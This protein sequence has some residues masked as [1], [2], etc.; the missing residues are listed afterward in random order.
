MRIFPTTNSFI[1]YAGKSLIRT[2]SIYTQRT[3]RGGMSLT[4]IISSVDWSA[5]IAAVA[6]L[7]TTIAGIFSGFQYKGKKDA[8]AQRDEAEEELQTTQAFFDPDNTDVMT[9]T[10][11]T[12][13]RSWT[14]SQCTKD[15]LMLN[16]TTEA[17]KVSVLKQVEENEAAGYVDYT[18]VFSNGYAKITYGLIS[19][20]C[21]QG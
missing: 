11:R 15:C 20:I 9:P 21:K 6:T 7:I 14:M 12:P 13:A 18:I 1:G 3:N 8:Q 16:C 10:D 4:T 17:D 19:E 2:L 5:I